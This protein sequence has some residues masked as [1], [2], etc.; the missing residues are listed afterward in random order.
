MTRPSPAVRVEGLQ[1]GS[2]AA[3]ASRRSRAVPS[4]N[5]LVIIL[6]VA[7][8]LTWLAPQLLPILLVAGG[9]YL[10]FEGGEKVLER[11][12]VL[13]ITGATTMRT[14]RAQRMRRKQ[15]VASA[16]HGPMIPQRRDR[17]LVW[18]GWRGVRRAARRGADRGR[19]TVTFF[20]YGLV[21]L[22]V[23]ADDIRK[24][25]RGAPGSSG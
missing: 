16:T 17:L 14:P 6:P 11:S 21:A 25:A 20:V 9:A 19:L 23:K 12:G 4:L 13:P 24:L 15:I 1:S 2:R 5:K 7:L 3:I 8:A 10:C 18:P 22:L